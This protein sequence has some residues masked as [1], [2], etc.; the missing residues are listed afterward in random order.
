M[1][2]VSPM[3]SSLLAAA[4]HLSGL[5]AIPASELPPILMLPRGKLN[6]TVCPSAPIRCAG[7][8]A[9]FD[10]QRY[11]IVMDDKLDLNEP[12]DASFLVHEMVH[13]LQFRNGGSTGFTSCE[14]VIESERQ[15]YAVQNAYLR[16]HDTP[17]NEGAMLKFSH[18]PASAQASTTTPAAQAGR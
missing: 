3:L 4:V 11:R 12:Y 14:A 17:G 16:E 13:V 8:T 9:A 7:L 2:P 15:A 5:P 1:D 10:T 6:Q 18:C